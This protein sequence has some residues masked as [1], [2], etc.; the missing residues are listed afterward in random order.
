MRHGPYYRV[1]YAVFGQ[2]VDHSHYTTP[3]FQD[4]VIRA[5]AIVVVSPFH[6]RTFYLYVSYFRAHC[7]YPMPAD[8]TSTLDGS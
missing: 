6:N 1:L 4:M 7:V 8:D 3:Y 2:N 5:C